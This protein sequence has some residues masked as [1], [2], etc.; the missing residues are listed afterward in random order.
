MSADASPPPRRASRLGLYLPVGLLALLVI[1]W[2]GAWFVIRGRVAS[3]L[4]EWIAQEAGA[5]RRWTCADRTIGGYPFRIEIRCSDF[6]VDKPDGRTSLGRLLVVSQVYRPRHVIAEASGPLRVTGGDLE[7][8]GSWKLL[9]ASVIMAPGGF[10]LASLVAEEP[11]VKIRDPWGITVD[12]S[13]RHFEGHVRPQP[14]DRTAVD[15]ATSSEGAVIPGLGEL[16]GGSERADIILEMSVTK[17]HELP[18][19]PLLR[20]LEGWREAGGSVALTKLSVKKGTARLEGTGTFA[21]DAGH[22]PEGQLDLRAE[23][24]GGFLGQFA[25]GTGGLLGAILGGGRAE[26]A[27]SEGALR[28]LPPLRM[29]DGRVLVGPVPV[30]GLRLPPL[31]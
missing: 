6:T 30:P 28:R 7:A 17:A 15:V 25:A 27:A 22:R 16:I 26:P 20:K 24:L 1:G 12:L 29:Q 18:T 31:Y 8:E 11:V 13:S 10:D 21:I 5:G 9:Q 23:G 14:G 2:S 4:D 19:Q 3:G